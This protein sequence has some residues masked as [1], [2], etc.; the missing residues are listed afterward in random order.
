MMRISASEYAK[1]VRGKEVELRE[2]VEHLKR[3][4]AMAQKVLS[5]TTELAVALESMDPNTIVNPREFASK[6]FPSIAE[7]A[8]RFDDEQPRIILL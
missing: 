1:Y 5:D 8:S 4:S 6:M 7:A 3:E 2:A